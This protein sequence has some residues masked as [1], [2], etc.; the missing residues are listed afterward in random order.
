MKSL[1]CGVLRHVAERCVA[2][3]CAARGAVRCEALTLFPSL[4]QS[5]QGEHLIEGDV[6]G[7]DR[8]P[9]SWA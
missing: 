8:L 7:S 1:R 5:R 4:L 9:M 6:V 2:E 3:R